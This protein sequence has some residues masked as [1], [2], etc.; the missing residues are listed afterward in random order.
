MPNFS[1]IGQN[2]EVA[3]RGYTIEKVIS[4]HRPRWALLGTELH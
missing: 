1:S 4:E 2:L 3:D